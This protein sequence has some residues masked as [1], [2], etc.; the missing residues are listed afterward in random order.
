MSEDIHYLWY[1]IYG[2]SIIVNWVGDRSRN[3]RFK[4]IFFFFFN[5]ILSC[6]NLLMTIKFGMTNFIFLRKIA[7]VKFKM[8]KK[9][10]RYF[11]EIH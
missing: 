4:I 11:L 6:N 9:I 7:S 2:L 8:E 1:D 10:L 3:D 5:F